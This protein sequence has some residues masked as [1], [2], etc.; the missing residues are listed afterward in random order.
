MKVKEVKEIFHHQGLEEIEKRK[1]EKKR[2]YPNR[3]RF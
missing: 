3:K 2:S 1:N